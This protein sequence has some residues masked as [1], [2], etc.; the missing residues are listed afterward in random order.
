V[1]KRWDP[2]KGKEK[3]A[4]S[5][6]LKDIQNAAFS[7]DGKRR[8]TNAARLDAPALAK[9]FQVW[10]LDGDKKP[11]I[12]SAHADHAYAAVFTADAKFIWT[13]GCDMIRPSE[14]VKSFAE[15]TVNEAKLFDVDKK[16]EIQRLADP[17]VC[18]LEPAPDGKHVAVVTYAAR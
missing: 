14:S 15:L 2:D 16:R 6:G 5:L 17:G 12:I 18:K 4:R 8:V 7:A 11:W 10:D 9:Q 13:R 1:L 3:S